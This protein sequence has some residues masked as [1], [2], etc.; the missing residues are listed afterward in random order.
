MAIGVAAPRPVRLGFPAAAARE[1]A[2][3]IN[4]MAGG[5]VLQ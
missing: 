1:G 2:L 4:V 5:G 3:L